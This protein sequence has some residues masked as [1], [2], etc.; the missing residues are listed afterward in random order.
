MIEYVKSEIYWPRW[1]ELIFTERKP[2]IVFSMSKAHP[3]FPKVRELL[4]TFKKT[5]VYHL[6]P[7]D[8]MKLLKERDEYVDPPCIIGYHDGECVFR[9][10][11]ENIPGKGPAAI[12]LDD[13]SYELS[14]FFV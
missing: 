1:N 12:N 6:Q 11:T 2:A 8:F 9:Y 5:Y 14:R 3:A 4:N 7:R 13:V 10:D